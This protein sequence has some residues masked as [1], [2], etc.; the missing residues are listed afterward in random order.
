MPV[1]LAAIPASKL[2]VRDGAGIDLAQ[3]P[4]RMFRARKTPLGIIRA[5]RP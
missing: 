3:A 5:K 2:A 1:L 4:R